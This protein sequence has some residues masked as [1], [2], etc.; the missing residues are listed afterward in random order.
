MFFVVQGLLIASG[1]GIGDFTKA[2]LRGG[3]KPDGHF[4]S[5]SIR[6]KAALSTHGKPGRSESY[7]PLKI[8][9]IGHKKP[10]R[11]PLPRPIHCQIP[12]ADYQNE[13]IEGKW[14]GYRKIPCYHQQPS[15]QKPSRNL[16]IP[17]HHND[18]GVLIGPTQRFGSVIGTQIGSTPIQPGL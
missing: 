12:R 18:L 10:S 2:D 14:T 3:Q 13:S 5:I 6:C 17:L 8:S 15:P 16:Q 9:Q 7:L 11:K 4:D 1:I